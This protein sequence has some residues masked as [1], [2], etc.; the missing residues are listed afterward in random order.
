MLITQKECL[1]YV[2]KKVLFMHA[3][4]SKMNFK[5]R[6]G[7]HI[8][9]AEIIQQ[10]KIDGEIHYSVKLT[11]DGYLRYLTPVHTFLLSRV[12]LSRMNVQYVCCWRVIY[13]K[14]LV[15]QKWSRD[16]VAANGRMERRV[17]ISSDSAALRSFIV[18]CFVLFFLSPGWV[19]WYRLCCTLC[20]L[21]Y[22][23]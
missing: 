21:L 10:R 14:C 18:S 5:K 7:V 22:A 16:Q 4:W 20:V 2:L 15:M 8:A 13:Y 11:C 12:F 3:L 9:A 23:W 1:K 17:C 6:W 19:V